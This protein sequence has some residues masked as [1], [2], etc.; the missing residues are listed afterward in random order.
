MNF[1]F[2]VMED[3]SYFMSPSRFPMHTAFLEG[4]AL[5]CEH[6]GNELGLLDDPYDRLENQ[7][8]FIILILFEKCSEIINH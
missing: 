5:Y 4:W 8:C 1:V 7:N 6:L 2:Q 3:R